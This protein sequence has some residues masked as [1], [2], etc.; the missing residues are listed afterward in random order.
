MDGNCVSSLALI[1][2]VILDAGTGGTTTFTVRRRLR[3]FPN[4]LDHGSQGLPA[5]SLYC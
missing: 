1:A 4:L 2:M 3:P 5:R